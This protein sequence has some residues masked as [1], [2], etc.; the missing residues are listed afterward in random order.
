MSSE[1]WITVRPNQQ[2][3]VTIGSTRFMVIFR[4]GK[5]AIRVW[6]KDCKVLQDFKGM[7]VQ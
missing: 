3:L 1:D 5:C 7:Q 2:T 4:D 6:D